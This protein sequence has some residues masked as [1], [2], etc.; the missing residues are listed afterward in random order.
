MLVELS[1]VEQRY[2]AVMEVLVAG[3]AVTEVAE[4]Y[5]VSRKTVHAWLNRYRE[6][7]LPGLVD[8]SHRPHGHRWQVA[9][10]V[11]VAICEL[12]R[13]HPRWGPRRLLFELERGGCPGP[14]PS[15]ST[16]YR[17]LVR[18]QLVPAE[19]RK[20]RREDYRRWER[21]VPMQLWQLDVMGSVFLVD[22][23]ELKLISGVDDHSRFCVIAKVVARATG[24][25]VCRAFVDAMVAFGVPDEVLT[26]N[27]K[28]FTA[29]FGKGGGEVLFDR[30]CRENGIAHRLT[31]PRSP[32]TTGKVERWHQTIQRELLEDEGPFEDLTA[33]QAAVD[34]WRT[35]YNSDRPHQS[36]DMAFP[37]ARFH[38]ETATD[39]GP[40]PLTVWAPPQLAA[41][42]NTAD[43]LVDQA[44]DAAMAWEP[45]PIVSREPA[46]R[47]DAVEV[48]RVV[49]ASG[50]LS[51]AG[52]QFWLGPQR[53][54][55]AVRFWID[56]TTVHVSLQGRHHK[57][58]PS[59]ISTRDLT[60][61]R[62][63][64]ARPAGPAPARPIS[65]LAPDA[66]I[67]ID[68][69]V[70]RVGCVVI[71]TTKIS[72]GQNLAGQ[73]VTLRLEPDVAHVIVDGQRHRTL[74]LTIPPEQRARLQGARDA[75]PLPAPTSGPVHVQRRVSSRGGIQ[76]VRQRVH[77]G[78]THAGQIVTVA[79]ED[80]L[81]RVLDPDTGQTLAVVPRTTTK[82]VTRFKAF[83]STNP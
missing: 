17:V 76:V 42:D 19:S 34:R 13:A 71:A 9:A 54:G 21:P 52:Q 27:G 64:G 5:G 80:Q 4:R 58:L 49:P 62:A 50:N 28:Q 15:R 12:R 40:D 24:R 51:I 67:E 81:L 72:V 60:R 37:A 46:R 75:G 23:T 83:R 44:D 66:V 73:R 82:E 59:R 38:P 55:Q 56:T 7:G 70:N 3:L 48:D 20:R 78:M 2:H 22:G 61:L 31:K 65:S 79:V 29:R 35:G 47:L 43:L 14:L 16:V 57:T 63:A 45:M 1:V 32:T 8:R 6:H 11:E 25:E 68:R 33:A 18:H 10:A 69:T 36:L 74:A 41:L 53:A 77:V 39:R 26:D 30:I